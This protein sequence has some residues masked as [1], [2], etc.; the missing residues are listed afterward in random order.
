MAD[1]LEYYRMKRQ[2]R[3]RVE[4]LVGWLIV[5]VLCGGLIALALRGCYECAYY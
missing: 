3:E 5:I 1:V 2:R 4:R